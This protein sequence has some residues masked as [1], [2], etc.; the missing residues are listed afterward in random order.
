MAEPPSEEEMQQLLDRLRSP[1]G[2]DRFDGVEKAIELG[3]D[4]RRV[5]GALKELAAH[6]PDGKVADAASVALHISGQP[7]P[8]LVEQKPPA[9]TEQGKRP[10][11]RNEKIFGFA[12]GFAAWFAVNGGIWLLLLNG[13]DLNFGLNVIL[14][15]LLLPANLVAL[16][17]L[18]FSQRW[19][20]LGVLSAIAANLVI[21]LV[22][23]STFNGVC[24]IPFF[25]K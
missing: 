1:N 9:A 3:L 17:I 14:N 7:P 8:P 21:A 2:Q 19:V 18:A 25:V 12:I 6:D 23:G 5:I 13:H 22:I 10:K 20:A 15:I 24:A 16:L 11:T 4:D